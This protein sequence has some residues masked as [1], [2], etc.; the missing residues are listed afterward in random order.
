MA[1]VKTLAAQLNDFGVPVND[2]AIMVKILPGIV[3]QTSD[4]DWYS[5]VHGHARGVPYPTRGK[6]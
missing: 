3:H 5:R 4:Q 6:I 2:D 1:T